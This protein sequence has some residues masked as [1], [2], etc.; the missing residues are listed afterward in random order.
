MVGGPAP[1]R[2]AVPPSGNLQRTAVLQQLDNKDPEL[3]TMASASAAVDR[4]IRLRRS[5]MVVL[6]P[7]WPPGKAI[8]SRQALDRALNAVTGSESPSSHALPH[9]IEGLAVAFPVLIEIGWGVTGDGVR[10]TQSIP[11]RHYLHLS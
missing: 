1:L 7:R 3:N 11:A 9:V 10:R 5:A 6:S 8:S 4:R 2:S